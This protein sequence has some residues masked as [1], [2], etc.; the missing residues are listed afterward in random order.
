[1]RNCIEK[2]GRVPKIFLMRKPQRLIAAIAALTCI[3][4]TATADLIG[5]GGMVRSVDISPDGRQVL[6][7]SFDYSA[8]LWNFGDQSEIGVLDLHKGPVTSVSFA[9]VGNRALTTSDDFTAIYWDLDTLEP[10]HRLSGHKHKVMTSAI[11]ASGNLAAT[12]AWDKTVKVWSLEDGSEMR[13][14]TT[15]SPVNA[16][17]FLSDGKRLLSGGHH[18]IIELWNLETGNIAGKLEGHLMGITAMS[19]SPDG[20]QLLSASI[21]KSIRLWDLKEM[22]ELRKIDVR[23]GQVYDVEI[24]PDGNRALTAGKD[25][26][27]VEWDLATG[28]PVHEI[29]AH[30]RI[31]WSATYTPDGRFAVSS[32]SDEQAR[33]WHI[34]TGDRIGLTKVAG[35]EPE[36]WLESD[37]PGA[38]LYTK[39]AKCHSLSEDGPARSGPHFDGLFN[40]IAGSVKGYRYSSALTDVDFRWD[41]TN[42]FRLFDE[43]P[44]KMLPGT[45]MP[46]QRVTDAKQLSE[47]VDYLRV[48]TSNGD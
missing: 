43:G 37:H 27:V 7:G 25:G 44:D 3:A 28:K 38:K 32:S 11:S 45:K 12:G 35:N 8:R 24:S 26:Y 16:V 9:P 19:L 21:D 42:L 41:E 17:V 47:L 10:L 22:V 46:V 20:K 23:D 40:R 5:H 15:N 34:E 48:L 13:T 31:A 1:M 4:S 30:D 33:I 18:P 14:I 2:I 29:A 6:T 36:P 39:C